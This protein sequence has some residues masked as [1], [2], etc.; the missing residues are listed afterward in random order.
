[1]E[2]LKWYL[3]EKALE[4]QPALGSQASPGAKGSAGAGTEQ[5]VWRGNIS[6]GRDFP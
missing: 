6:E 1:M 2:T 5:R 4:S 3:K